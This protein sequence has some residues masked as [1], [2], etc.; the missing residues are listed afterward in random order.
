MSVKDTYI[1]Y[2]SKVRR[3]SE[4]TQSIYSD[5]LDEFRAFAQADS[6]DSICKAISQP[7]VIRRYLV[8]LKEEKNLSPRTANLHLSVLSGFSRYLIK[9]GRIASNAVRL[10]PRPR[11]EKRLPVFY[12][13]DSMREYFALTDFY[14]SEDVCAKAEYPRILGRMIISLL[15][16]TGIRRSELISL[17]RSGFEASRRILRV[18]GKGDKLRDVPVTESLARELCIYFRKVDALGLSDG[19][20]DTPM[21]VSASGG[22]LYPVMVDRLVKSELSVVGGITS[23]KSPHVL[24]HTIATALLDNGSDI[25]SI[26]EMLGHSSLAATQVYTHNS[27]EKLK[28]VYAKAHPRVGKK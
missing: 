18:R 22:R 19:S 2:I 10:V 9:D 14:A 23:R 6:D 3:Y 17:D 21:L 28:T 15:Y 4:R 25:N 27:I 24:R 7:S 8:Y 20:D 5:V 12:R 16:G 1:R 13:D 11:Q 26:K